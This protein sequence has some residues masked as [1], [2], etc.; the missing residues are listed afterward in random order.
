MREFYSQAETAVMAVIANVSKSCGH[1]NWP[2]ERIAAVVGCSLSSVHNAL[3]KAK[4]LLHISVTERPRRGQKNDTNII[5]IISL[6]WSAWIRSAAH[7]RVGTGCKNKN[8]DPTEIEVKKKG[9]G[10]EG[11]QC[12][13]K[14]PAHHRI[15]ELKSGMPVDATNIRLES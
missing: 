2:N 8:F 4:G 15:E 10:D 14:Q 3:R 9:R 1:C 11:G 7:G 6:E 13:E 5:R 12:T